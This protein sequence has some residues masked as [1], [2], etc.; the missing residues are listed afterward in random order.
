M[1]NNINNISLA[2][3]KPII[4][5]ALECGGDT[6]TL[7]QTLGIDVGISIP[8]VAGYIV[9]ISTGVDLLDECKSIEDEKA[10]QILLETGLCV[11]VGLQQ[12]FKNIFDIMIYINPSF[13]VRVFV[14]S[15]GN[16]QKATDLI[17][18]LANDNEG[19]MGGVLDGVDMN[20][21]MSI[22]EKIPFVNSFYYMGALT[23]ATTV[24]R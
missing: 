13:G 7:S 22:D 1:G 9:N 8:L 10:M 24:K 18:L 2:V 19:V 23:K 11:R 4:N 3:I 20:F 15:A 17:S 12:L 16:S 5:K 14:I 6:L 21:V